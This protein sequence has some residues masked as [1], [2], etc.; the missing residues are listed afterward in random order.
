VVNYRN[1]IVK[2]NKKTNKIEAFGK[3]NE[4]ENVEFSEASACL[5]HSGEICDG[6]K[7]GFYTFKPEAVK[8]RIIHAPLVFTRLLLFNK[9]VET[10]E[11][12]SILQTQLDK[13]PKI[14]FNS[15]QN[16]FTIEFATLDMRAPEKIQYA[17]SWMVLTPTG[18]MC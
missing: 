10:A 11:E 12:G 4:L 6:S 15:K 9:E 2:F 18:I 16:V 7:S 14:E 1:S 5:L 17:I 3:G 13:S 8:R